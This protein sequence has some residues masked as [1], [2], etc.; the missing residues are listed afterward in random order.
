MPHQ[1]HQGS[2]S[3]L[4]A[5]D[6]HLYRSRKVLAPWHRSIRFMIVSPSLYQI[7]LLSL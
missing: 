5:R 3:V 7:V 1:L 6:R 2:I 4:S